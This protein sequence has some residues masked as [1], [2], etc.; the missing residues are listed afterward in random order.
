MC[1]F[2]FAFD[3]RKSLL[4]NGYSCQ[5]QMGDVQFLSQRKIAPR[6]QEVQAEYLYSILGHSQVK[7][8][9]SRTAFQGV[10]Q[11]VRFHFWNFR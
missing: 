3:T 2:P 6:A 8:K 7:P 1:I 10:D 11:E 9:A 5:E 4:P